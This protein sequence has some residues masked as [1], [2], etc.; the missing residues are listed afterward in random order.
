MSNPCPIL[1]ILHILALEYPKNL[2]HFLLIKYQIYD[3]VAPKKVYLD[4]GGLK[5]ADGRAYI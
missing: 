4:A 1:G 3:I 5:G 2:Y